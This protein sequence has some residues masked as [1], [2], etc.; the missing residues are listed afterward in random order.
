MSRS[1]I[2]LIPALC[3]L[4]VGCSLAAP[5]SLTL[6]VFAAASLNAAFKEIG[7]AYQAANPQVSLA[8]NIAGSQ[9]LAQQINQGAPADIFASAD[10]NQMEA[11]IRGGRVVTGTQQIFAYNRLVVIYSKNSNLGITS[12]QD[13]AK[14]GL[15]IVLADKAVPV[16]RYALTFLDK[17]DQDPVLGADFKSKVLQNVVSFETD[18]KAVLT[19]VTLGEGDAGI[20]YTTDAAAGDP[21]KIGEVPIPDGLNVVAAYPIAPIKDSAH[22]EAAQ[23]FIRYVLSQEGQAVLV[24]Y[25]FIPMKSK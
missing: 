1:F 22:L 12:L 24:K 25:G 7:L 21:S 3:L 13:L 18:V 11:A 19:K 9:Q 2:R 23:G 16:G 4:L 14:P 8:F 20:V 10:F 5:Q 6:N 15:K 17:A